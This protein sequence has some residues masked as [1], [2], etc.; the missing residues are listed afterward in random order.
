MRLSWR[1]IRIRAARF[2]EKW[3]DSG[4]EKGETHSFYIDF[5][6]VFGVPI[7]SVA[8][9]EHEVRLLGDR[10]GYVDVF[11]RGKLIVEQKSA[12]RDLEKATN[13]A[14]DYLAGMDQFERPQYILVCDFQTFILY[15]LGE[16]R[17]FSFKLA[18]FPDHIEKFG[19]IQGVH[20]KSYK[21]IG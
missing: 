13:Q 1:E 11:W 5:F 9:F 6:D 16:N 3:K 2:A 12:G 21:G 18:D 14:F 19:F 4:Y 20:R 15:D 8:S 7:H 17:N 10:K